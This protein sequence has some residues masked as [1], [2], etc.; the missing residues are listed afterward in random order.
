MTDLSSLRSQTW[1]R[2]KPFDDADQQVFRSLDVGAGAAK[3]KSATVAVLGRK[4]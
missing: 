3:P 4:R 1:N 2:G